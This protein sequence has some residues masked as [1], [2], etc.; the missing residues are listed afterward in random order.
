[1]RFGF[2]TCVQLGLSCM[3]AIYDVGG[4]LDLAITLEDDMA[5][6]KSGRIYLDDFCGQNGVDLLKVRN[7]N[8]QTA[9]AAIQERSIDWLFIIGWS[10][11]ARAELLAS[12]TQGVI[13]IHP[14]LLPVGR[15]RAAIPWAIIKGLDQTG[16][17]MFKLDDGVDTGPIIAQRV[18]PLAADCD[19]GKLYAA[20]NDAHVD[21]IREVFPRLRDGTIE[22][23]AQDDRFATEWP[24]R[25]PQDGSIDLAGSVFE[26]ERLV[27]A[28]TRP[29]PGAF[30]DRANGRLVIWRAHRAD[31][32]A[33]TTEMTGA[34]PPVIHF[35]DG[36][37]V[38]DEWE[39]QEK[40][41]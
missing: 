19:A 35:S 5:Q 18:I 2:V 17:T 30:V 22:P 20:V 31:R 24:G 9:V 33:D 1:M 6:A 13:G 34:Q 12:P 38:V 15:G 7:I 29:Y 41:N 11:I 4:K 28:T 36:M 32:I 27:R 16:V 37:L 25:T 21:L 39:W 40:S 10:Q 3:E 23:R 8:N 14:T 26:A